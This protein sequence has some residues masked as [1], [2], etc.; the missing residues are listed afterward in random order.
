MRC[1]FYCFAGLDRLTV[2]TP[3]GAQALVLRLTPLYEQI[4]APLRSSYRRTPHL[5]N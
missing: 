4:L 3:A 2:A 1:I 5:T